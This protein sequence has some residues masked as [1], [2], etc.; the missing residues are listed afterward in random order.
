MGKRAATITKIL[1]F[2]LVSLLI[3]GV[4]SQL[5]SA[6]TLD[7]IQRDL[8]EAQRRRDEL[9]G[10]EGDLYSQLTSTEQRIRALQAD[11]GVLNDQ[12]D[13]VGQAKQEAETELFKL[14]TELD[15]QETKLD[16]QTDILNKRLVEVYKRGSLGYFEVVMGS[17]DFDD[18]VS[19]LY[20]VGRIVSQDRELIESITVIR[21]KVRENRDLSMRKRHEIVNRQRA[22]EEIKRPLDT[23]RAQLEDEQAYKESLLG[24]VQGDV[25]TQEQLMAQYRAEED[26]ILGRAPGGGGGASP[27]GLVWPVLGTGRGDVSGVFHEP[28]EYRNGR[29]H[30]VDIAA[31]EGYSVV[32]VASGTVVYVGWEGLAGLMI[33]IN[34]DAG[35]SAV[36]MHLSAAYVGG[37]R[38]TQGQVIGAVGS[39]GTYSSG[40][41][42]HFG[43]LVP[44]ADCGLR[45][46]DCPTSYGDPLLYLP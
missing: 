1:I 40:P 26:A 33:Q 25:A 28:R 37:G 41:H 9:K 39:T 3:F 17:T 43:I 22:I 29:H 14:Q 15:K 36:Y 31:P 8:D 7:E 5:G 23:A 10:Q 20:Y 46:L 34:H 6:R 32:S 24:K 35:Y 45:D 30:G 12:L 21:D 16:D 18:F 27:S 38:V 4:F 42:L 11:I 13:V 44:G 2:S 19:S